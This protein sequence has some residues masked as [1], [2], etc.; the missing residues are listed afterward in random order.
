[1]GASKGGNQSSGSMSQGV[2]GGQE[3]ALNN[4]YNNAE[5]LYGS[6]SPLGTEQAQQFAGQAAQGAQGGM[7]QMLA[8]GSMGNTNEIRDRLMTSL[9]STAGGSQ[10]GKMYSSIVGGEGNT[11][12]DPMVDAMRRSGNE[13]LAGQQSQSALQA[14]AMGQGGSSRHAMQNAMLNRSAGNDMMDREMAMRGNAYDTDLNMKM[15]IARQADAGIQGTQDRYMNML[16]AADRN[17]QGGMQFGNQMQNL[18][19]GTM[20]PNMQ[21]QNQQWGNMGNYANAIGA[22]TVLSSGNQSSMGKGAGGSVK[23]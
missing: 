6:Q 3:G 16:G 9:D 23:G 7:N 20:A 11:Y 12:I 15:D 4:L 14:A 19:M 22:P 17:V 21:Q 8:G 2:W 10:T 18:G 1:M 13:A 5:N